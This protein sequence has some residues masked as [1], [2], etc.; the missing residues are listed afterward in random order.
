MWG[1]GAFGAHDITLILTLAFVLAS[2]AGAVP[3]DSKSC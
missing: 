2:A 1:T 3:G